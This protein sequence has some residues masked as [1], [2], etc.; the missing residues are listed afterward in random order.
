MGQWFAQPDHT[1]ISSAALLGEVHHT[2]R[3]ATVRS[4]YGAPAVA[5]DPTTRQVLGLL[6][7]TLDSLPE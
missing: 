6:R 2:P 3:P 7:R 5:D 1:G 4:S